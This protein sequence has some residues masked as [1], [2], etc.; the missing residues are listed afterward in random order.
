MDR[1][2][3]DISIEMWTSMKISHLQDGI[4]EKASLSIPAHKIKLWKV[5]IPTKDINDKKMKILINK[6]HESINVKE[7]LGGELLDTEDSISS[8]IENVSSC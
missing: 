8:K 2:I 6:S 7:E 4:K 5:D 3:F 1:F